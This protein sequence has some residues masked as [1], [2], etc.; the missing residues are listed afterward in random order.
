MRKAHGRRVDNFPIERF[1]IWLLCTFP[2]FDRTQLSQ[3]SRFSIRTFLTLSVAWLHLLHPGS[4]CPFLS[5]TCPLLE[6]FLSFVSF[7]GLH[8]L[9][10]SV[11]ETSFCTYNTLLY[12]L[13]AL[14]LSLRFYRQRH[15]WSAPSA[16]H[17]CQRVQARRCNQEVRGQPC[18]CDGRRP[19]CIWGS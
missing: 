17:Q 1:I 13:S 6:V 19:L 10:I 18:G 15:G 8:L 12:I 16:N 11:C 9:L 14:S 2:I 7:C 4:P 3:A 5:I